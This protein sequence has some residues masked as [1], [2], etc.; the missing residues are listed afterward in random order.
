[1][2]VFCPVVK[3]DDDKESGVLG[4]DWSVGLVGDW[5]PS[6]ML[7]IFDNTDVVGLSGVVFDSG[8]GAFV[9]GGRFCAVV[10][11]NVL[12]LVGDPGWFGVIGGVGDVLGLDPGFGLGSG[13]SCCNC[14]LV[15]DVGF[16]CVADGAPVGLS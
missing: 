5:K 13:F 9:G 3:L 7:A 12:E 6:P 2:L 10:G 8:F 4:C 14:F 16:T 15:D 1:M 11:G